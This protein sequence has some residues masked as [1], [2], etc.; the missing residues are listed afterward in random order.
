MTHYSLN[1]PHYILYILYISAIITQYHL[2]FWLVSYLIEFNTYIITLYTRLLLCKYNTKLQCV[3][4]QVNIWCFFSRPL[5]YIPI[6]KYMANFIRR[7]D[8]IIIFF[9]LLVYVYGET[10]R[11]ILTCKSHQSNRVSNYKLSCRGFWCKIRVVLCSDVKKTAFAEILLFV[12]D[13][14]I[15]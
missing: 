8:Y 3:K 7:H 12:F 15:K 4:I 10:H 13:I 1:L 6:Y 14:C 5:Y 9:S 11:A 2:N